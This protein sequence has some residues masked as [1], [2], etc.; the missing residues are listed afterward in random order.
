MSE[1]LIC[2]PKKGADLLIMSKNGKSNDISIDVDW[3]DESCK[4]TKPY[5]DKQLQ[6]MAGRVI[7]DLR[8]ALTGNRLVTDFIVTRHDFTNAECPKG[9]PF[10]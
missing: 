6:A 7:D 4:A 9:L 3:L 10:N 5:T 2:G 8:T 1:S